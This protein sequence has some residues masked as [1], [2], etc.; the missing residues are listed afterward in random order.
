MTSG[1]LARLG[2]RLYEVVPIHV[3]QENVPAA[4]VTSL[5]LARPNG[6]HQM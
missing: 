6:I 3:I 2:Q 1:F 4:S 5:T